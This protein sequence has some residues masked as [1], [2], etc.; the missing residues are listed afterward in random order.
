MANELVSIVT[1]VY[2]A[3]RFVSLTIDSVLNQTYSNW[4]MLLIN[5]G[6]TDN[7]A[8]II[9]QYVERDPRIKLFS[10]PN[11]GSA[12][13][14]NN[15]IRM[16]RGRYICLLDAD[17]MWDCD[18]LEMQ[19]LLMKK[20]NAKLVY[21][22]FRRVDAEGKE[23][24]RPF[25]VPK[26]V[27]YSDML[28]T[29]SI[30]CLTGVY[31]TKKYGKMF[32]HEELGSL[33][34]DYVYWLEILKKVGLAYGNQ[35]VLAS[36]RILSTSQTHDKRKMIRPQFNVYRNILHMNIF[37]CLYYLCCWAWYGYKKYKE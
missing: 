9:E 4:E 28:V 18:F 36:Y 34:D 1:P 10:Q 12:S 21:S 19:L 3:G 24:L 7:S 32:L 25:L 27:T 31:D 30:G 13:A 26:Q 5:D 35:Q 14:R 11:A 20:H 37:K 22:S 33:R 15:G 17:D 23:C 6:S 29:N 8:E 16:A 2:N